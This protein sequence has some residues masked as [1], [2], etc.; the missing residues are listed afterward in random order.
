M[1]SHTLKAPVRWNNTEGSQ[2]IDGV[3]VESN[4][5]KVSMIFNHRKYNWRLKSLQML[6][7]NDQLGPSETQT[8]T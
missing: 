5:C 7:R 1:I 3:T 2:L 4:L 6:T 8:H